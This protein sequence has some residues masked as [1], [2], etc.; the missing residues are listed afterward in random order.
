MKLP[1]EVRKRVY[2]LYFYPK[3]VAGDQITLDGKRKTESKDPFAKSYCEGSKNRVALLAVNKEVRLSLVTSIVTTPGPNFSQINEG[4][5]P[6]FYA[7][8]LRFDTPATLMT[9]FAGLDSHLRIHLRHI[10]IRQYVKK[11]AKN[12]LA[13]L[14]EAK[15]LEHLRI[16][17]NVANEDDAG[18]AAKAF[19]L[20]ACKLLE[21]VGAR[22]EKKMVPARKPKVSIQA[23]EED[24]EDEES[25]E[26]GSGDEEDE[27]DE[28]RKSNDAASSDKPASPGSDS[29]SD[30]NDVAME[31]GE[32][33]NDKKDTTNVETHVNPK[34]PSPFVTSTA[35]QTP[36]LIQGE[37]AFAVDILH[38]GR[39]ALKN[40][41]G[42]VWDKA[43]KQVFLDVL[44]AKLK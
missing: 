29:R 44:E 20:D 36:K 18:K 7:N 38:F 41:N 15:N 27:D 10:E 26:E 19:W 1:V 31:D 37:K 35:P 3:G 22:L 16:E 40:K 9:F 32:T 43:K 23:E 12:A 14:A 2:Q 24:E 17:L 30:A 8:P 28:D 42:S 21:S 25:D 34:K 39:S 33:S 6:I 11:D 5:L 13:F 4:A